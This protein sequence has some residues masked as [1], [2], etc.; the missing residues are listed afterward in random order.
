MTKLVSTNPD[1]VLPIEP[2]SLLLPAPIDLDE[3]D[4]VTM[5][6]DLGAFEFVATYNSL[7]KE[8]KIENLNQQ[9][10]LLGDY[11]IKLFLNDGKDTV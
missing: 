11:H 8:I 1:V 10:V 9:N 2:W 6:V 4:H 3:E 7:N 5:S